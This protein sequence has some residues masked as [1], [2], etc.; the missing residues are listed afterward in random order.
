MDKAQL[1]MRIKYL[2][3]EKAELERKIRVGKEAEKALE[4]NNKKLVELMNQYLKGEQ[5]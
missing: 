3:E 5:Q 2:I 4:Y 1:E